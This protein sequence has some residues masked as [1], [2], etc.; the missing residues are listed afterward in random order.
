MI[1]RIDK[2]KTGV[3]EFPE[4]INLMSGALKLRTFRAKFEWVIHHRWVS[5]SKLLLLN[6]GSNL[7]MIYN[8]VFQA[9]LGF[10]T[11]WMFFDWI[12]DSMTETSLRKHFPSLA[13]NRECCL[14]IYTD[15]RAPE[16]LCTQNEAISI[17]KRHASRNY[18]WIAKPCLS[19]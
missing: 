17:Q 18:L 2:N 8:R 11:I 4:F 13:I 15:L 12:T 6:L 19:A 7:I 1:G 14:M 5:W 10:W 3:I 9:Q 16:L